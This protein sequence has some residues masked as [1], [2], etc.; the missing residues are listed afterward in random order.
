VSLRRQAVAQVAQAKTSSKV[1]P[2][3]V[4]GWVSAQNQAAA[5][6]GTA[7]VLENFFPTA[8]G[9]EVMG[10]SQT[11]A[12]VSTTD[13]CESLMSYIGGASEMFGAADGEIYNVTTVVDPDVP[14]AA[15]V[16]G[17]TSNYYS[18]VNFATAGG[19]F[20]YACNDTDAP[21][22]YDGATWQQVTGVSVPIAITGVT[23]SGLSQVSVYR[24]R[25]FFVEKDTMNVWAL[26][27][28]A[29]GGAAIQI[30]L[31]GVFRKGGSV[32]FCATWSLDSGDGLDD[33]FVIVSTEGEVAIYQGSDPS[34]PND[35]SI[36]G[37]YDCP[38]PMGKNAFMRAGGDLII[39]T[40]QGAIPVS[41]A[42]VK[43]RAALAMASV[44]RNIQ[45][46][47]VTDARQRKTLPWEVAKWPSRNRAIFSV[48]VTSDETTTPPWCFVVNLETGAWC[49]RT[50]WN[51]RCLVLHDEFV[52]FGTNDG[53]VVKME[54]TGSDDGEIYT[55]KA[56][57]AWDHLRSSG[58]EK[59]VTSARAQFRLATPIN[60]Q[61]SVSKDYGIEF[62]TPPNVAPTTGSPGVWDVGLWDD[63]R[64]DTGTTLIAFDT[65]WVSIGDT[66][67][68]I[69]PQVQIS[70][71][72]TLI[73]NAEF[74]A[75]TMLYETGEIML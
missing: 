63:A 33:K 6:P 2:A 41:Q 12:T 45:P 74:V 44:S 24:N 73:P 22:L 52:Y 28:A 29:L 11:H 9:I 58:F 59:T 56:A 54:I 64:W 5:K 10:G 31:A 69:A 42:V 1:F 68:V 48:P 51:T 38:A 61:L 34:D 49:K 21:Q 43:D 46:D 40:E 32:L 20:L 19:F 13:P 36:V 70:C 71:G 30:S 62:P 14:P 39:E 8:T 37:V 35:W 17:Q 65:R 67:F 72:S 7:L 55:A 15:D 47:W 16:T 60:P 3:P 53:R 23:T 4:L 66:G 27:A 75:M 26:A 25:L 50:G 18:H 57:F